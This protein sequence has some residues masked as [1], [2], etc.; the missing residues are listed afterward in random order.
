[1][2]SDAPAQDITARVHIYDHDD[3]VAPEEIARLIAEM[4]DQIQDIADRIPRP[5]K[6]MLVF[7]VSQQRTIVS[8][9]VLQGPRRSPLLREFA[10]RVEGL[11]PSEW[12]GRAKFHI[13]FELDSRD[14]WV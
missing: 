13:L 6:L 12:G 1:M 4:S 3:G 7:R 9:K 2:N 14:G 10:K 11:L 8:L 5:T